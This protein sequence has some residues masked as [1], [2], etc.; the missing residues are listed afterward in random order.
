MI[1]PD[2]FIFVIGL[3]ATALTTTALVV[4]GGRERDELAAPYNGDDKEP[5]REPADTRS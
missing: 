1:V 3:C 5:D 4:I 2:A